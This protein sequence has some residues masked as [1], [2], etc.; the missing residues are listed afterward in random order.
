MYD[1]NLPSGENRPND[2]PVLNVTCF[3]FCLSFRSAAEESAFVPPPFSA[4]TQR[5]FTLVFF[6]SDT[7]VTENITHFPLGEICGSLTRFIAIRSANVIARFAAPFCLSSAVFCLSFRSAAEESAFPAVAAVCAAP[8]SSPATIPA[9][10]N[11]TA[12][13]RIFFIAPV[14][15]QPPLSPTPPQT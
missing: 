8:I 4:T 5:W 12:T 7:S 13:A 9:H 11:T 14:Y 10:A 3:S 15:I 6:S 1:T 2:S